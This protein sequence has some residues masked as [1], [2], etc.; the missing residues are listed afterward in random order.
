MPKIRF[1]EVDPG[2]DSA[3]LIGFLTSNVFPYH[4]RA[5][6][7]A[8]Q[9]RQ[10][11]KDGRFGSEDHLGFWIDADRQRVGLAVLEDLE[12]IAAGGNPVFDLRLGQAHRGRGLGVPILK[13][14]TEQVFGRF[15]SLNRF[16]G[17]TREDNIAMR[18]VFLRS[19]FVKEAHHRDAWMVEGSRP[20]AA[21]GY[22]ILRRDWESGTTTTFDWE[23]LEV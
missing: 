23:D 9:V 16:E 17:H 12:D 18:K 6:W 2:R 7:S 10:S 4:G 8:D 19:G 1:T 11:I 13:Q 3:E 5:T 15:P 14:L 20:K 22:A 21:V